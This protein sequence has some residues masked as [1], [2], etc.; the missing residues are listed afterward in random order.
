MSQLITK[1]RPTAF[2][3]IEGQDAAVKALSNIIGKKTS[4]TFLL[5]GP[6]GCGKTTLARI[7]AAKVGA[8]YQDILEVDAATFSGVERV[9]EIQA[10][11][12]YRPVGGSASRAVI[13][14]ECHRLSAQAWDALLKGVEEPN[15][16][17]F[18]FFCTTNPS[19]VPKTIKTRCAAIDLKAVGG[20]ALRRVIDR[21]VDREKLDV[22][23]AVIDVVLREAHESPRQAIVNLS[24]VAGCTTG[25]EARLVL[26]SVEE[27]DA[28]R[29]LCAF[30]IKGG[31][32][33]KCM[34]IVARLEGENYEGV[35]I[36]VCNFFGAVLKNAK[37]DDKAIAALMVLENFSSTYN[38]A[39]GIAPLLK[40]IGRTLFSGE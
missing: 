3:T 7:A 27:T 25:R 32:W 24:M 14:D 29:E 4:Q 30:L 9:R 36:V 28:T 2:K 22:P 8:G 33:A 17:V 40:S 18:W 31:S 11:M 12:L 35:R 26:R 23:D 37:G 16:H 6:S 10:H 39:E 19:K 21:I 13:M 34:E 20:D 1:H 5:S 15:P 38:Q